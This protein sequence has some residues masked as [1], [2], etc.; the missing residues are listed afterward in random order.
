MFWQQAPDV[1][2]A[3]HSVYQ[4]LMNEGRDDELIPLPLAS[5]L[6]SLAKA[7]E[8]WSHAPSPDGAC[9]VFWSDG[10]TSVELSW[11]SVHVCAELRPAGSWSVEVANRF[12]D[13]L[14]DFDIP[15]FDPQTGERFDSWLSA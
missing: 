1:R 5:V 6:A 9:P 7:F 11:S 12:I 2:S 10:Q 4:S 15:H 13:V 14:A 3:P 8:G